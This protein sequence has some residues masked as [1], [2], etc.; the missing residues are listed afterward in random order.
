[1]MFGEVALEG[2]MVTTLKKGIYGK[3]NSYSSAGS[4]TANIISFV[5]FLLLNSSEFCQ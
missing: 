3:G 5:I 2:W 4:A 1:M